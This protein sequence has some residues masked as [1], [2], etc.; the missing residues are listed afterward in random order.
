MNPMDALETVAWIMA[1]FAFLL[2]WCLLVDQTV[3][4]AKRR[5][6][7]RRTR[8]LMAQPEKDWYETL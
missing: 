5:A 2:A 3:K 4:A 8:Q 7:I 1:G 6:S